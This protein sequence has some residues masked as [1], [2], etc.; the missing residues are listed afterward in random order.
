L[1]RAPAQEAANG[2]AAACAGSATSDGHVWVDI[3]YLRRECNGSDPAW[4]TKFKA[5]LAYASSK[6]W[7]SD[8]GA[9]VRAH[10]ERS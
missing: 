1:L 7:M 10:V 3:E 6:G 8:D 2:I 5:M 4:A 9:A